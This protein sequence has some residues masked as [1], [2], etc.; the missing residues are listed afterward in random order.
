MNE[1][2]SFDYKFR[3][4]EV[5]QCAN[6]GRTS[7][8]FDRDKSAQVDRDKCARVDRDKYA[9]V[10]MGGCQSNDQPELPPF[11]NVKRT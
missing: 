6:K 10:D 5:I 9:R 1:R 2:S 8:Q 4:N 11:P 3:L 7:A